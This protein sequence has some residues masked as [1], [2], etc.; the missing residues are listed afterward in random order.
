MNN[1]FIYS[2]I[3]QIILENLQN[4]LEDDDK[5][6]RAVSANV[7]MDALNELEVPNDFNDK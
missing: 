6:N 1:T 5:A 3:K 2:N 7:I 4:M